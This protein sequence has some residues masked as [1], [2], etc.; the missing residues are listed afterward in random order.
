MVSWK[1]KLRDFIKIFK[2]PVSSAMNLLA[3]LLIVTIAFIIRIYPFIVYGASLRAYDP[4]IQLEAARYIEERGL[5]VFLCDIDYSI[6]YPW[7]R[8]WNALYIGIPLT[9]VILHKLLI[10]LG[11]EIDLL[12]VISV[13]PAIFGSLAIIL[14]YLIARELK[15]SRAGLFAAFLAAIS[16]GLIQ[17][18][19]A[20][21]YDN[22]SVG[23]F[24][25]FLTIYLF[26]RGYKKDSIISS[27]LAGVSLGLLGWTW[28][29]YR[30][31]IDLL[32]IFVV[33]LWI[34]NK[35]DDK[36]SLTYSVSIP[37][38]LG[39]I[40]V[41]PRN[42]GILLRPDGLLA[43]FSLLII[44]V[45]YLGTYF[46]ESL[47]GGKKEAYKIILG[48]GI[49]AILVGVIYLY[50]TGQLIDIGAKFASV[51]NPA[52]RNLL[53]TFSSVSENQPATWSTILFGGFLS[54]LL[55]PLAINY[56][57]EKRTPNE[58]MLLL[59][60]LTGFYFSASISRFIVVGAPLLAIAAGVAID[61][62]LEPFTTA[63]KGEWILHPI[64]PV[65]L[66]AGE[67]RLPRSEA[68]IAYLIIGMML[69]FSLYNGI[70][71][72]KGLAQYD[73]SEDELEVFEYLRL[74]AEPTDVVLSWWDYGYRLK[75][76]ANVTTLA[77]NGTNNSTQ[78]GIVGAMLILPE[79][80]SIKLLREYNVKWVVVYTVD[81][82]KAIWMIRIA[83]K[84]APQYNITEEDYFDEEKGVYKKP[85]FS[86]MLWNLLAYGEEV[87]TVSRWINMIGEESLRQNPS[88][89][90]PLKLSYFKPI[91]SG[92]QVKLYRVVYRDE[93]VPPEPFRGGGFS[94]NSSLQTKSM[95]NECC[96]ERSA[97]LLIK[98]YSLGPMLMISENREILFQ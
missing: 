45:N 40:S 61:Y 19:I 2:I 76:Y 65:R 86:S 89:L 46:G 90:I 57:L 79:N 52:L 51:I 20:G 38:G 49:T 94:G 44:I 78:M 11:Y 80:E 25:I 66:L 70:V 39:L 59:I 67:A 63:L 9:G 97:N 74:Y 60:I 48:G 71:A 62:F 85:F 33:L 30:Y 91:I 37:I 81:L 15:S 5:K 84:H 98:T 87:S 22:E 42:Y 27:V 3:L 10:L 6:W 18:T 35:L 34:T 16:P 4:F 12:T 77:D 73:L 43:I 24:L 69:I 82:F 83:E 68:V 55:A 88:G 21:F 64:R 75:A 31:V 96:S 28:G 93:V 32:A 58:M 47:P 1:E 29:L 50:A 14:I 72:T 26:I 36:I 95:R 53:P 92:N 41:L 54:I 17:R 56:I 23:I 7:G 13:V 8:P